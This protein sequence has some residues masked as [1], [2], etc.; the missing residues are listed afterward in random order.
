MS[1]GSRSRYVSSQRASSGPGER[2]IATRAMSVLP[3]PG[4][5]LGAFFVPPSPGRLVAEGVNPIADHPDEAV[6][7]G[8]VA[9][10]RRKAAAAGLR[11]A[12]APLPSQARVI[13]RRRSDVIALDAG[14]L[15]ARQ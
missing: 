2:V 15:V 11:R 8:G 1:M 3:L 5:L 10:A 12:A 4:E 7:V 14:T 9:A 6:V 13:A